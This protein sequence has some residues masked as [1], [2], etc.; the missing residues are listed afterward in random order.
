VLAFLHPLPVAALWGVGERTAEHLAGLGLRTVGDI[1]AMPLPALVRALGQGTA[2]HLHALATGHDPRSVV[3]DEPDRSIGAEE[4][5]GSDVTDHGVVHRE[6]LRLAEKTAARLRSSGQLG[7]TVSIKVRFADFATITRA[8]TLPGPT[9]AGREIYRTARGLYDALGLDRARIRLI[10]VR[11]EGIAPA[12]D[13]SRQLQLGAREFGWRDADRAV[14]RAADR[15]GTGA[16]R[17]A[18]LVG[19]R[20]PTIGEERRDTPGDPSQTGRVDRSEGPR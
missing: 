11:V 2:T 17:P 15:F 6:L 10:G 8:R 18:T 3:T 19:G 7:R 14:D 16:V 5:F 1:A 9:D 12:G 4:T 13:A 20:T